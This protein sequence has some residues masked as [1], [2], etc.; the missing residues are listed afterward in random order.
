MKGGDFTLVGLKSLFTRHSL[1]RI[2]TTLENTAIN[3]QTILLWPFKIQNFFRTIVQM[4]Y[5]GERKKNKATR[6][7]P[8]QKYE[9]NNTHRVECSQQPPCT[10]FC[11][12]LK[13][14]FFSGANFSKRWSFVLEPKC[15]RGAIFTPFAVMPFRCAGCVWFI[16]LSQAKVCISAHA[17]KLLSFYRMNRL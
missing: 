7:L 11:R 10:P 9:G 3:A 5:L 12:L 13:L 16:F 8:C 15:P 17:R 6:I 4:T 14:H 1:N 2:E